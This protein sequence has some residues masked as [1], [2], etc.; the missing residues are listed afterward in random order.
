[1]AVALF[2]LATAFAAVALCCIRLS[3]LHSCMVVA[4]CWLAVLL[5]GYYPL[6][7]SKLVLRLPELPGPVSHFLS[8]N[9]DEVMA[10]GS[11]TCQMEWIKQ[12]GKAYRYVA[13][14]S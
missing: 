2:G 1:M 4:G 7:H 11:N 3:F 12:Y 6:L 9:M 8:G 13:G 10:K 14:M 5:Y